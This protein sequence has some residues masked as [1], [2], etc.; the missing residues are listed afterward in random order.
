MNRLSKIVLILLIATPVMFMLLNIR[1]FPVPQPIFFAQLDDGKRLLSLETKYILAPPLYSILLELLD[2]YLPL[3]EGAHFGGV[4]LNIIVFV[5][6]VYISWFFYYRFFGFASFLP[7]LLIV[8]N[9]LTY[10]VTLQPINMALFTYI[11][12]LTF[13]LW[14]KNNK[15]LAYGAATVSFFIRYEGILLLVALAVTDLHK[16]TNKMKHLRNITLCLIPMILWLGVLYFSYPEGNP[17]LVEIASKR[18]KIPNKYFA[19]RSIPESVLGVSQALSPFQLLLLYSYFGIGTAVL[20]IKKKRQFIVPIMFMILYLG[21][22]VLYPSGEIR[23]AYPVVW[24]LYLIGLW[25]LLLTQLFKLSTSIIV[26]GLLTFASIRIFIINLR[27]VQ[28]GSIGEKYY[29]IDTRLTGEWLS[30]YQTTG[31]ILVIALEP[32]VIRYYTHNASISF[33]P[34][35]PKNCESIE[36]VIDMIDVQN[37]K[38]ILLVNN[39][40]SSSCGN[41]F[42][43]EMGG[44]AFC[45]FLRSPMEHNFILLEHIAFKDSWANIY[46]L[47]VQ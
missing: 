26:I 19:F 2:R 29:R 34:G 15:Q 38:D 44:R 40:F 9:P 8:T 17:N 46:K 42:A 47:K 23:Y 12:A 43:E 39:D 28:E 41:Y 27:H 32:H 37:Y 11:C 36:C 21:L 3:S 35:I 5:A 31:Q 25:P 22:H 24:I 20:L 4:I 14:I 30:S 13:L 18:E 45:N 6:T 16:A 7:I 10:F 33:L 1:Y